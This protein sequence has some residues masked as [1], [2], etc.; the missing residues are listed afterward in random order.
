MKI[1]KGTFGSRTEMKKVPFGVIFYCQAGD[2]NGPASRTGPF[3]VPQ[4]WDKT[5]VVVAFILIDK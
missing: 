5:D 1:P 4:F 2:P 3:E